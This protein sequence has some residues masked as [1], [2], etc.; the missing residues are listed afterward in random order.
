M[1]RFV[2][3]RWFTHV[4]NRASRSVPNYGQLT[5]LTLAVVIAVL[6]GPDLADTVWSA[7]STPSPGA[8]AA[9]CPSQDFSAFFKAFSE[10]AE[11]QRK[12]TRLPLEYGQVDQDLVGTGKPDFSTRTIT[13]FEKIPLFDKSDG[14]RI[15]PSS[16]KRLNNHLAIKIESGES[17]NIR[18]MLYLPDTG[19]HIYFKFINTDF[20]WRLFEV[21]DESV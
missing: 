20:C 3:S 9:A 18:V 14:G 8:K 6:C 11:V 5:W 1:N 16:K 4:T 2:Y 21:D 7:Q 10:S 17:A 15:F 12:F 19:F 13:S